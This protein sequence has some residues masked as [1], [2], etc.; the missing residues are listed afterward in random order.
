MRVRG[1]F[2]NTVPVDAYRG[3]GRPEAAYLIERLVDATARETRHD[4]GRDPAQELHPAEGDALHDRDRHGLR[5][6]RL[7]RASDARAWTSPTGR[8]FK[9]RQ[10]RE[11]GRQDARHRPCQLY[12]GLRRRW[13]RRPNVAL[14]PMDGIVDRADRHAVERAGPPDGLCAA[15]LG[16][17]STFRWNASA[18]CRATPTR[19]RPVSAPAARARSRSAASA[20]SATR[21]LGDKLKQIASETLETGVGRSRDRQWRACASSAPTSAIA[22]PSSRRCRARSGEC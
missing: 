9:A 2:T 5:H 8:N 19:S 16:A 4:A 6:R 18:S 3:A 20:S 13:A 11:Q 17:V 1:V 14:E 21:D 22:S 15:G 7:R 10:G 12:R